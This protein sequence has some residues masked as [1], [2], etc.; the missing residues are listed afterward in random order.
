M[1]L[2]MK[3]YGSLLYLGEFSLKSHFLNS[4][5]NVQRIGTVGMY[6]GAAVERTRGMYLCI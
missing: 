3:K 6:G 5:S 1:K 4:I 2:W